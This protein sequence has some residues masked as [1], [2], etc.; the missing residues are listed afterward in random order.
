MGSNTRYEIFSLTDLEDTSIV[1]AFDGGGR[2]WTL[3]STAD[4]E[5]VV[6]WPSGR[7]TDVEDITP[8]MAAA[9]SFVAW[10]VESLGVRP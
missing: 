3:V 2:R 7:H 6:I 10:C 5:N 4:G 8:E 9:G 1:T